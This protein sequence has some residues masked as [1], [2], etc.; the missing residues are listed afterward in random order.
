MEKANRYYFNFAS[1][2]DLPPLFAQTLGAV[3]CKINPIQ[4]GSL[5]KTLPLSQIQY[6]DGQ[7]EVLCLN[8]LQDSQ[9]VELKLFE[10]E[11]QTKCCGSAI[12][13]F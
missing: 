5:E 4:L 11:A 8:P 1:L 2:R 13:T 10:V 7:V 9:G 6:A 3:R 12:F